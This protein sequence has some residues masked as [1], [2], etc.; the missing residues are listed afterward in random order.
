MTWEIGKN[1]A[2]WLPVL[3]KAESKYG[4]PKGLLARQCYQ[5]SRFNP[6]ARN[7]HSGCIGLMQLHPRFFIGA[8]E[9]PVKDIYTGGAYL[10][11]LYKRFADWQLA[12]AGYNWG[13]RNLGDWQ[14]TPGHAFATLP[15]E[16]RD[17]VS[18]I[19]ADVPVPGVLCKIQSPPSS[20]QAGSLPAQPLMAAASDSSS[21]NS[22]LR[23]VTSIFRTPSAPNSQAQ[24][25]GSV[26]SSSGIS[27]PTAAVSNLSQTIG[28][29][30]NPIEQAAIPTAVAILQAAK[31]FAV[32]VGNDPATIAA[33]APGALQVL[34]GTIEMQ[35][36]A[37]LSAELGAAQTA[38]QAKL[39]DLITKLQAAK[40]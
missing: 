18:E 15:K 34:V 31:Q 13:P 20:H 19:V 7:P 9:D 1:A 35:F 28:V 36:P 33:K 23:S 25:A 12:L 29:D 40:A 5:E 10:R 26:P 4:I 8:G 22:L 21:A 3:G 16:T 39:D 17:Y 32:N 2:T 30:M 37:L 14:K 11:S 27:S 6:L 24:S 38:V